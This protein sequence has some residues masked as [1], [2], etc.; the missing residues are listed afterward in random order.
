MKPPAP[1]TRTRVC[2]FIWVGS[3]CRNDGRGGPALSGWPLGRSDAGV[4]G[5]GRLRYLKESGRDDGR[6]DRRGA[7]TLGA[8][9]CVRALCP[10]C[11]A[12]LRLPVRLTTLSSDVSIDEAVQQ[13]EH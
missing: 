13:V 2:V 11:P 8:G 5:S 4:T 7:T 10:A 3:E 6:R 1:V 12:R 9:E